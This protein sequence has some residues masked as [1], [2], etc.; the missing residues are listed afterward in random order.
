MT[1][2]LETRNAS[3]QDL[4]A[5]LR[6]Q[7]A[8]K[9]DA[10]VDARKIRSKDALI[11]V[12]GMGTRADADTVEDALSARPSVGV[13]R[14]TEIMDGHISEKLG[15]PVAYL[16]KMRETRPDLYDSN[17]NGW[18]HGR[19][20]RLATGEVEEVYA[21]D[22]RKFLIRTFTDDGGP[23]IGRA[24]LSDGFGFIDHLDPLF[25]FLEVL[26]EEAPDAEVVT[27]NLSERRMFLRVA[28]PSLAVAA[29]KLLAGYRSPINPRW[30][31][32]GGRQVGDVVF[33]GV[34]FGNSET[35]KG[36]FVLVPT[37]T[38]LSC[39]NGATISKDMV[40]KTH[41]GGRLSEGVVEWSSETRQ[42]NIE[43]VSSMTRDAM[44]TFLSKD[45]WEK[46][47]AEIETKAGVELPDP[48]HTIEIVAKQLAFSEDTAKKILDHFIR[49]GQPTAGG[50]FQAIT[51][52]AQVV[53]SSDESYELEK[54]AVSAI[55]LAVATTR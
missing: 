21:P 4:E 5:I 47:I 44:R 14:P 30:T 52:V 17:V 33:A 25:A 53:A 24:M 48:A 37:A 29:S 42:K 27:S 11:H 49:G 55:D 16:R 45:Y 20:K 39:T 28:V 8:V 41:L 35:G 23:G 22:S 12:E 50:V 26:M 3:L 32:R 43:L 1:V 9:L 38:V 36:R 18:L 40:S 54:V 6:R 19:T 2:T 7:Q 10:V 51:S 46:K 34:T 15:I 13:F 31:P